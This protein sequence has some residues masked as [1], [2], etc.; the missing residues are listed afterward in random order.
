MT[1]SNNFGSFVS[2]LNSFSGQDRYFTVQRTYLEFTDSLPGA[3]LLSEMVWWSNRN[4]DEKDGWFHMSANEW[5]DRTRIGRNTVTKFVKAWIQAGFLETKI[6]RAGSEKV[7]IKHYRIFPDVLA[8]KIKEFFGWEDPDPDPDSLLSS[9]KNNIDY[10]EKTVLHK[11]ARPEGT[12]VSGDNSEN[13]AKG[14]VAIETQQASGLHKNANGPAQKCKRSYITNTHSEY[15][16]S[17]KSSQGDPNRVSVSEREESTTEEKKPSPCQRIGSTEDQ[18]LPT[19]EVPESKP[20]T[21][22]TPPRRQP[23][24]TMLARAAELKRIEQAAWSSKVPPWANSHEPGDFNEVVIKGI[25]EW[26]ASMRPNTTTQDAWLDARSYIHKRQN[27]A[28]PE[29]E[30]L[31]ERAEAILEKQSQLNANGGR[32]NFS[33]KW[34]DMTLEQRQAYVRAESERRNASRQNLDAS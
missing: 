25:A 19:P 9:K 10:T 27:P 20:T 5:H 14:N 22:P 30:I 7:P 23:T 12:A 32:T 28:H 29:H 33:A 16:H 1:H 26:M 24:P 8:E 21:P 2:L 6:D 18:D 34:N 13:H 17:P 15:T 3:V 31:R 4:R 11:N